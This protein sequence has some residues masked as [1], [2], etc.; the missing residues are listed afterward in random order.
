MAGA[1]VCY[2]RVVGWIWDGKREAWSFGKRPETVVF[3]KKEAESR[4]IK[5]REPVGFP[6]QIEAFWK[7]ERLKRPTYRTSCEQAQPQT[8]RFAKKANTGGGDWRSQQRKT[9]A[10]HG[11]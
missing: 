11:P 5:V 3:R 9:V 4:E 10:V 6:T 2:G 8:L 7:S 1:W